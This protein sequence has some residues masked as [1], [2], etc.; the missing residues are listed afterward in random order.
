MLHNLLKMK[1]EIISHLTEI[2]NHEDVF[3]AKR[4]LKHHFEEFERAKEIALES[5][6]IEFEKELLKLPEEERA[7]KHFVASEDPLDDEFEKTYR[8]IRFALSEKEEAKKEALKKIYNT[9]MDIIDR[10]EKLVH[11]ENIAKAFTSFNELKEEW[12]NAGH[13]SRNQEKELHDKH[14]TIVKEFYY[15]MNIYKELKAYDFEKNYKIRKQLI[16]DS[17]YVLALKSIKEKQERYHKIREKWYDAG[18]VS[19]EQYEELHDAWKEVDNKIHDELGEYYDKLHEEQEGNLKTKKELVEKIKRV[20]LEVLKTHAKWQKKTKEIL[21]IQA[22]WKSIGFARR[23]ENEKVWKDFRT[24]CDRFF[25]VKQDFYDHLKTEQN[26]NKE[27]KLALVEKAEKLRESENWKDATDQLI[28]LQKDWKKIPPAHHRDEK[29]LWSRFREACN[30]FFDHKKDHFS[31]VDEAQDENLKLKELIIEEM[32]KIEIS[33]DKKEDLLT[34]KSISTRWNEIGHVPFRDKD[35]IFKKY[36]QALDKHY[37]KIKLN[38]REK[39]E[40]LFQQKIDQFKGS[41]NPENALYNEKLFLKDKINRLNSDLIQY[42]NNMGFIN[43]D[44]DT[45]LKGLERNLDKAQFDIDQLKEKLSM[46]NKALMDI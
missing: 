14:N 29:T 10:I 28:V 1:K 17:N 37:K 9:K 11:E 30:H 38:D 35:K 43:S 21:D 31:H 8:E 27:A 5:E 12:K 4:E 23:K 42:Q 16:E 18:P 33:G 26:S 36:Q 25:E 32:V 40:I 20:D 7:D 13:S 19:R 39:I 45:L 24:E 44:N 34:L 46:V 2:L 3:Q 15:N 22:E 41:N 6:K